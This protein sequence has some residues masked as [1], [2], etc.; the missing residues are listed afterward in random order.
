[1]RAFSLWP[2]KK[3]AI[4]TLS[5]KYLLEYGNRCASIS[6]MQNSTP[7]DAVDV[8]SE[9][10]FQLKP[11]LVMVFCTALFCIFAALGLIIQHRQHALED[12]TQ[13]N[14]KTTRL[15]S[16]YLTHLLETSTRLLDDVSGIVRQHGMQHLANQEGWD[17]LKRLVNSYPE[18]QSILLIQGSG[19]LLLTTNEPFSPQRRVDLSDREYFIQHRDGKDLVFGEQLVGRTSGRKTTPISRAIRTPDGRLQGIVVVTIESEIFSQLFIDADYTD[20]KEITLLREDGAVFARI[21]EQ[22]NP[23]RRFPQAEV[24]KRAEETERGAFSA[25]SSI[26]GELQIMVYEKLAD[27]PLVVVTSQDERRVLAP[28]GLFS[29]SIVVVLLVLLMPL[30]GASYHTLRAARRMQQLQDELEKLAHTDFLTGLDNRRHFMGQAER[31]LLRAQRYA[32]Q[33]AILMFDLDHFKA[34]ND[35]YG[36]G[37]G[38]RVLRDVAHYVTRTLRE[39]DIIGR[40]GG[41]EFAILLPQADCAQ[42]EEV[43]WRLC[44][45]VADLVIDSEQGTPLRITISVG[46]AMAYPDEKAPLHNLLGQADRALYE[47]KN[48]GRNQ[49]CATW[50]MAQPESTETA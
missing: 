29:L 5:V 4:V 2:K 26:S 36:H 37:N 9:Q 33:T 17:F 46:I 24:L 22:L 10:K 41:E 31:E 34:I 40:I 8:Q 18:I 25:I 48:R 15:T 50:Q 19:Q 1:M 21:P 39:A 47:A 7:P 23:G 38:D 6:V 11:L 35:T 14:L 49:V 32:T 20:N 28:W 30:A 45:G 44:K 42:A 27:A 13:T 16:L 3:V 12:A 43:A